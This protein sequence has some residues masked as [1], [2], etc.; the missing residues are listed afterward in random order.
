MAT[1]IFYE[2]GLQDESVISE[3]ESLAHWVLQHGSRYDILHVWKNEISKE[4]ELAEYSD[5]DLSDPDA[6]YH[7]CPVPQG[8]E[9]WIP[10]IVSV[11][12]GVAAALL[13]SPNVDIPEAANQNLSSNNAL[14]QRSNKPR[15]DK[16]KPSI[17]GKE[18]KAYPDLWMQYVKFANN[19]EFEVA[20]MCLSDGLVVPDE[21]TVRDGD[22]LLKNILAE[23][24]EFYGPN[25]SPMTG[26][27][28]ILRIGDPI[29]EPLVALRQS[30]EVTGQTLQAPNEDLI[31]SKLYEG[32]SSGV[33][34]LNDSEIDFTHIYTPGDEIAL[35]GFY[36]F[37]LVSPE[38][39][40]PYYVRHDLSGTYEILNVTSDS[41][42]LDISGN[43]NWQF[44]TTGDFR[45]QAYQNQDGS[46]MWLFN[47]ESGFVLQEWSVSTNS[48]KGNVVG[49]FDCSDTSQVW[50]NLVAQ[51]G[52][53]KK[54]TDIVFTSINFTITFRDLDTGN[55]LSSDVTLSTNREDPVQSTF[56]FNTPFTKCSVEVKRITNTDKEF[57][58]TVVDEVKW[59]D[60]YLV[61]NIS[62]N[63]FGN[64]TTVLTKV[65]AVDTALR[66]KESLI[67]CSA[68]R[69][70]TRP[71]G[72]KVVSDEFADV[73]FDLHTDPF[74]G[75]QTV[76]TID[77]VGLYALQEQIVNYWGRGR[78]PIRVGY[79]FDDDTYRYADHL[80]LICDAVNVRPYMVGSVIHFFF[81]GPQEF[82]TQQYGH[83]SKD[84]NSVETRTRSM[85]P[86]EN[87]DGIEM[88]YKDE[89]TGDFETIY[90]PSD[91][92]ATN[93]EVYE[94]RGCFVRKNALARANRDFN[95]LQYQRLTHEFTALDK[96]LFLVQ[97]QR[98][99][100][101]D[102]TRFSPNNG[103][104]DTVEGLTYTLSQDTN[105][106]VGTQASLVLSKRDGSLEGIPCVVVSTDKVQLSHAPNEVPYTGHMEDPTEYSL[107]VDNE[108]GKVSMLVTEIVPEDIDKVRVTT[109][110]YDERYYKDDK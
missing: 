39:G 11:V 21:N 98:V 99:G 15:K 71:N 38:I 42:T 44:V 91:Q 18:P 75:R 106:A 105:L 57:E 30:N 76:S 72:V 43:N 46:N 51:R 93:P 68:T 41:L 12:V 101:V 81:E 84:P 55:T 95:K 89:V 78:D 36:S 70:I 60:L 26:H 6:T 8:P 69:E 28:P 7:I 4:T 67:S 65:R 83:R 52:L 53:Y 27:A 109:V 22:T 45:I 87:Y 104:I 64:V 61:N 35:T 24:A 63:Q 33:V 25:T 92:S 5:E 94:Y 50:L 37:E 66:R 54:R 85:Y 80:K 19:E 34:S 29:N 97:G 31:A 17:R 96:A 16:R 23:S 20:Y 102:N 77:H 59:R 14:Q 3:H 73:I 2:H 103:Y 58:G 88:T 107:G 86:R 110:N 49:P 74:V 62:K 56:E 79:T 13:I 9:T 82:D 108:A 1:I 47:A 40:N 32:A 48:T 100:V 90:I 10:L